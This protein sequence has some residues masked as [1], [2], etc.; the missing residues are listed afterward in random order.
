MLAKGKLGLFWVGRQI[1]DILTV[2]IVIGMVVGLILGL[3]LKKKVV[4]LGDLGKL[5][6]TLVKAAAAPL[7]FFSISTAVITTKV[8]IKA[9]LKAIA[10]A[11]F[12]VCLAL[13]IGLS[14]SNIIKPGRH[15]TLSQSAAAA[16]TTGTIQK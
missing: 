6:I 15:M 11:S 14:Y 12:N 5:V 7:L 10:I 1:R 16:T 3:S 13:L 4:F 8:P 9:A 2:Q